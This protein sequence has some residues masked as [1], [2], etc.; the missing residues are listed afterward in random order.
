MLFACC[1]LLRHWFPAPSLALLSAVARGQLKDKCTGRCLEGRGQRVERVKKDRRE[2]VRELRRLD[3]ERNRM[4]WGGYMFRQQS[5][6]C[7][8][9]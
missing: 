4:G 6:V 3:Q 8:A 1:C 5:D 9:A 2:W 7:G